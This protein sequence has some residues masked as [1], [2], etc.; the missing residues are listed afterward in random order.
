MKI[1]F[2]THAKQRMKER[3]ISRK[4]II[5]TIQNPDR[6][7]YD[8]TAVDRYVAK[9]IFMS[10]RKKY[11]LLVIYEHMKTETVVI[12]VITTS[13]INKYLS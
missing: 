7:A 10:D 2:L 4:L 13:K 11:L 3:K 5:D 9:K 8:R 1:R 12:T 6:F